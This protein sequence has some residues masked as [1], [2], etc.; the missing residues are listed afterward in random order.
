MEVRVT[1]KQRDDND[2]QVGND[3]PG[4][5]D[6]RVALC[7]LTPVSAT[8]RPF[9]DQQEMFK[10]ELAGRTRA[11]SINMSVVTMILVM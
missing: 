3:L 7:A 4:D 10:L 11:V 2:P 8:Y 1:E 6:L 5:D 9:L